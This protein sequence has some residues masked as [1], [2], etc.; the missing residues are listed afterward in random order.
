MNLTRLKKELVFYGRR[1]SEKGFIAGY[2]GNLSG[3]LERGKILITPSLRPKG[4]LKAGDLVVTDR[5]GRKIAGRGRP[6]SE[7]AMHIIVYDWRPDIG[8]CCHAHPPYATAFAAIG[9]KLPLGIL[10]EVSILLGDIPLVEYLPT[11][12]ADAWKK[13]DKYID[14]HFA[15]LLKNHGVLTLGRNMEEA[16]ARMET[17][18]H[19]ARIIYIGENM[20]RLKP[21][22]KKEIARLDEIRKNLFSPKEL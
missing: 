6:S 1:L 3:R 11:G 18:E 15:F 14:G 2:D 20:G 17:V 16:F 4:L 9:L 22:A 10:P 21:L 13:F 19:Y 7:I 8:A 5:K 12:K